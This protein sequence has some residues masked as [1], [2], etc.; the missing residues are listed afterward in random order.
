MMIRPLPAKSITSGMSL[1]SSILATRLAS[2]MLQ[3]SVDLG[4]GLVWTAK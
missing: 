2:A 3:T 4:T 1:P